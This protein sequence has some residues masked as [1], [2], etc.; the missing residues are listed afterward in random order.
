M[1][2]PFF[3]V[4]V[5]VDVDQ[6]GDDDDN[7]EEVEKNKTATRMVTTRKTVA[8]KRRRQHDD[9]TTIKGEGRWGGRGTTKR[10]MGEGERDMRDIMYGHRSATVPG[11]EGGSG[12]SGLGAYHWRLR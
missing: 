8:T 6:D 3:L 10:F 4:V 11:P 1:I 12:P 5:P 2:Q 7:D 9:D